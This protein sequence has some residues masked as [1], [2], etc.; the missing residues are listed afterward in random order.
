M[1]QQ[2]KKYSSRNF[3]TITESYS[4]DKEQNQVCQRWFLLSI[5]KVS[6]KTPLENIKNPC[7]S[8]RRKETWISNRFILCFDRMSSLGQLREEIR[9]TPKIYQIPK[10]RERSRKRRLFCYSYPCHNFS[11]DRQRVARNWVERKTGLE[12]H[13]INIP[14][15]PSIEWRFRELAFGNFR[16][17]R[18][19]L[20]TIEISTNRKFRS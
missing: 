9:W 10:R 1:T 19:I 20:W 4:W 16:R 3:F 8:Y 13:S 7:S 11:G 17:T 14:V 6:L 2:S 18:G 12:S 15:D 5:F